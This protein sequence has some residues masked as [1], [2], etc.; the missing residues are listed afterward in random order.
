VQ[1][2]HISLLVH[3]G[4]ARRGLPTGCLVRCKESTKAGLTALSLVAAR[5][6]HNGK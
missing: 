4:K 5:L 6:S 1:M 3:W 2:E